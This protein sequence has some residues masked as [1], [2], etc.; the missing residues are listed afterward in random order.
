[1]IAPGSGLRARKKQQVRDALI[2]AAADLF[3]ERGYAATTIDDI[4]AA[5]DVA[6]RTFFRYFSS[7]GEVVLETI[8]QSGELIV[9]GIRARPRDEDPWTSLEHAVLGAFRRY[10][11]D[12]ARAL[13]VQR[14]IVADPELHA[15]RHERISRVTAAVIVELAARTGAHPAR[16]LEPHLLGHATAAVIV[17][18]L[19]CWVGRGGRVP[20]VEQL[21]AG[22]AMVTVRSA[23]A[24]RARRRRA[25]ARR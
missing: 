1:M 16:D 11:E 15:A 6:R 23:G 22:F 25:R 10:D 21:A 7:K 4:V 20:L 12:R 17:A 18:A 14:M 3:L 5:A 19:D 8:A 9:A 24:A 2:A 13:A